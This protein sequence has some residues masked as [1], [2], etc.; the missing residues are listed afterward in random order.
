MELRWKEHRHAFESSLSNPQVPRGPTATSERASCTAHC[1]TQP[2]DC[3][4]TCFGRNGR[5]GSLRRTGPGRHVDNPHQSAFPTPRSLRA[6]RRRWSRESGQAASSRF[7]VP[8]RTLRPRPSATTD[9]SMTAPCSRRMWPTARKQTPTHLLR[10]PQSARRGWTRRV[11]GHEW[12]NR[13]SPRAR[14]AMSEKARHESSRNYDDDR[15]LD[16][17]PGVD[18]SGSTLPREQ[19]PVGSV[20]LESRRGNP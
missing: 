12:S 8:H 20:A 14:S 1:A 11:L 2:R 4:H 15:P 3:D 17:A 13:T 18:P 16:V 5:R 7:A 19:V 10:A 9:H 6:Q